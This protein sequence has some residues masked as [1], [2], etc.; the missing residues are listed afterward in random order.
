[1]LS[2]SPLLQIYA[3]S[4]I[5]ISSIALAASN[6]N[7]NTP[8]YQALFEQIQA[9][10]NPNNTNEIADM[11][12]SLSYKF[13]AISS[14]STTTS[15]PAPPN[16]IMN[17]DSPLPQITNTK[18]IT[19]IVPT[20]T[21]PPATK[22]DNTN[23]VAATYSNIDSSSSD[24]QDFVDNKSLIES[25]MGQTASSIDANTNTSSLDNVKNTASSSQVDEDE[26][27]IETQTYHL[28]QR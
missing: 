14:I 1:M 19:T 13:K 22:V 12:Q 15:A 17:T 23:N 20:T 27:F 7:T 8:N 28:Y 25:I 16:P 10:S 26:S 4:T 11:L 5:S 18:T 3:Y 24:S 21:S 6:T 2:Q 9:I